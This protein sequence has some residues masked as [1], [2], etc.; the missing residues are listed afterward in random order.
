[1]EIENTLENEVITPEVTETPAPVESGKEVSH[2]E[3]D[4]MS[5]EELDKFGKTL[6]EDAPEKDTVEPGKEK[7][8]KPQP[9]AVQPEDFKKRYE[10]LHKEYGRQSNEVGDLRKRL[11]DFE[12]KFNK[13]PE[14]EADPEKKRAEYREKILDEPDKVIEEVA[15]NILMAKESQQNR[16]IEIR[17]AN[18][19]RFMESNPEL[20]DKAKATQLEGAIVE[21]LKGDGY[22]DEDIK[23]IQTDPFS[24]PHEILNEWT[25][26]AKLQIKLK[27]MEQK[28]NSGS[29]LPDRIGQA[30]KA[31]SIVAQPGQGVPVRSTLTD[32]EIA[33]LSPEQ[34]DTY[35]NKYKKR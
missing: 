6:Q 32:A 24:L 31:K 16:E 3:I 30:A 1:M 9:E 27:E 26:R 2:E 7:T 21:I 14:P 13:P 8:E 29:S 17:R 5:L 22:P 34:I 12:A 4:N 10:E 11:Q 20:R 35:L 18:A 33:E 23:K 15:K 28:L 19:Q 25:K